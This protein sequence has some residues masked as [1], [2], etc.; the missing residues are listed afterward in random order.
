MEARYTLLPFLS[1]HFSAFLV[2]VV[3]MD[4]IS[5]HK[6]SPKHLVPASS[7]LPEWGQFG[8]C[9]LRADIDP[10]AIDLILLLGPRKL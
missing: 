3:E 1:S 7:Q 8:T 9:C 4:Q 2:H 6:A 10:F 5:R